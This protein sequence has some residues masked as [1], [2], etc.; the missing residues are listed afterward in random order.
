LN[1]SA[2]G[3]GPVAIELCA[4]LG[5]IGIGLRALGFNVARAYDI[6]DE[7]VGVYNHNVRLPTAVSCSLM[8]AKGQQTVE[9]DAAKLGEVEILAAGP[10]CKGFSQLRNGRHDGRN[11]HNRVLAVIPEYVGR[12]RPR[13]VFIENVPDLA[14]HR[15]GKTLREFAARLETPVRGLKYRVEYAIYDAA[16]FGVPQARRRIFI[17]A[18]RSGDRNRLPA[19]GPDLGPLYAS[20]RHGRSL[21]PEL[22]PFLAALQNI[23]DRSL[24]SAAQALSDLPPLGPNE[25]DIDRPYA[26]APSTAFQRWARLNA[27][28]IVKDTRTPAVKDE[29]LKRL[30]HIPPGGCA[31][32]IPE[33][34]LNGLARR[35]DSAYRRLH[36]DVPSTALSTKYDCVYHYACDR[37]LSVREYAR[38]QGLPDA[39]NF[40][41]SIVC[42]RSAYELIG[43]SVPPLMVEGVLGA[44]LNGGHSRS[45]R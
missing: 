33:Q 38:L 35:Y 44:V 28:A 20:I 30:E 8:T 9:S 42:R 11:G 37:S 31:R 21:P 32:S 12:L 36:P 45:H 39:I 40:P 41:S 3:T 25:K 43:N 26:M 16:H 2:E 24:T 18:V 1:D 7:A 15:D 17:L 29:T 22:Q 27:A 4:G 10:P 5:G 13:M 6:W 14:R 23:D 34:H 19:P